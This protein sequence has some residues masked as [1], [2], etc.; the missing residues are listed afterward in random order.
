ML[1]RHDSVSLASQPIRVWGRSSQPRRD[2]VSRKKI[3]VC[4]IK[5]VFQSISKKNSVIYSNGYII[6][7]VTIIYMYIHTVCIY[8]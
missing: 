4:R 3:A 7:I 8:E 1:P 2:S 5:N 6:Y